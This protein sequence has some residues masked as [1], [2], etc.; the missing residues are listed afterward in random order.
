[1]IE[2]KTVYDLSSSGVISGIL[3]LI[4]NG[5]IEMFSNT[6]DK[7]TKY[8]DNMYKSK[9]TYTFCLRIYFNTL[10]VTIY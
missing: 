2:K 4:Y 3:W 1:M 8:F 7:C 5:I 10:L 6:K 9:I